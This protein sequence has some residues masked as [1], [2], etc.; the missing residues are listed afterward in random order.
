M[1]T[2]EIQKKMDDHSSTFG[3]RLSDKV[4]STVGS[5]KFILI[6]ST[7]IFFWILINTQIPEGGF[8]LGNVMVR[9][10]DPYPFIFLNLTLSFQAAYTAPIIMMSQ[11]R[12]STIDRFSAEDDYRVNREA[13]A[14][15]E[16]I[17]AELRSVHNKLL[18]H[19]DI[20][21][22]IA[23]ITNQINDIKDLLKK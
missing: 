17:K 7:I 19:Q 16:H 23:A 13:K 3:N 22:D 14:D 18:K 15:V 21:V 12:Q 10:W 9:P 20:Q 5:W 1:Y 2:P 11:N 8:R 4:A 6:Q